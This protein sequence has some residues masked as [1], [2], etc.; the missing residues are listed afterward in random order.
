MKFFIILVIFLNTVE[1]INRDQKNN[2]K[3][4][5]GGVT[6]YRPGANDYGY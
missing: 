1:C 4:L 2:Q 5:V 6:D 3:G